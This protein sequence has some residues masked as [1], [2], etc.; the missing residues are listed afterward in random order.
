[1]ENAILCDPGVSISSFAW[2]SR[3]N[4]GD[5]PEEKEGE[6]ESRV[7]FG[8]PGDEALQDPAKGS[9]EM[10]SIPV[11]RRGCKVGGAIR[12]VLQATGR[13]VAWT[14]PTGHGTSLSLSISPVQ[15][16][17]RWIPVRMFPGPLGLYRRPG[18][19]TC[20]IPSPANLAIP[21]KHRQVL[22][23]TGG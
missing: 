5:R 17:E 14:N 20:E 7:R 2:P 8:R 22:M 1:M 11:L 21:S 16:P 4:P 10:E 13:P 18:A 19:L 12:I 23:R 15:R 3:Q 6:E 9:P